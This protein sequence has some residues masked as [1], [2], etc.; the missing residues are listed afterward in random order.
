MIHIIKKPQLICVSTG[1]G[2]AK[3]RSRVGH[4]PACLGRAARQS[5]A[6][7]KWGMREGFVEK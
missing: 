7:K 3:W 6:G 4:L 2:D 5:Q 1:N